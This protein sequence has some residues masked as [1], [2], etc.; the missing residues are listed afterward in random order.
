MSLSVLPLLAVT[1]LIWTQDTA[2]TLMAATLLAFNWLLVLYI[3]DRFDSSQ[4]LRLLML[5]GTVFS[6]GSILISVIP[7]QYGISS[8]TSLGEWRGLS[9]HK[10]L[11]ATTLAFLLA[12]SL[13]ATASDGVSK[14]FRLFYG[15]LMV[16]Q[17]LMTQ[18]RTGWVLLGVTLLFYGS[19]SLWVQLRRRDATM[20]AILGAAV[21]AFGLP[22]LGTYLPSLLNAAG[23][24]ET[25]SGRTVIWAAVIRSILK[26]PL[27]GY[28]YGG[29]WHG[30]SGE[31]ANVSSSFGLIVGHAHNGLLNVCLDLG[32]VG[33]GLVIV[34]VAQ[35]L[36]NMTRCF[37]RG[38]ISSIGWYATTILLMVFQSIDE[39][40]MLAPSSI[41]WTLYLLACV[42]L[43][44]TAKM[45]I[46]LP[47]LPLG[48]G[49]AN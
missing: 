21:L 20:V 39:R 7:P 45:P 25:L 4:Q 44:K 46:R 49:N 9:S 34:T 5:L 31:S 36:W 37:Q 15:I 28:G 42:G 17:I 12:P 26:R 48:H 13:F 38:R 6:I 30:M 27:L 35:A 47:P 29:F 8:E 1:S 19:F 2:G 22:A 23:R 33:T 10:N 16:F 14:G 18:S 40:G 24:D 11:Y 41:S 43:T 32:L 3:S